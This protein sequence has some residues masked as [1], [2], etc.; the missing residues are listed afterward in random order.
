LL[1]IMQGVAAGD[2]RLRPFFTGLLFNPYRF[3]T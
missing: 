1:A 3:F 2:K